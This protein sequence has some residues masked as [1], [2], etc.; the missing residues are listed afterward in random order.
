[1]AIFII[2]L[3][4][5][6][7]EA[8]ID[9]LLGRHVAWLKTCRDSG[10]FLAWGR[11]VPREGGVILAKAADRAEIES[12]AAGDPFV[13]E[14]AAEVSIVEWAPSFYGEGMEALGS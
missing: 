5:L 12:I 4:Y 3:E 11:K 2:S 10:H 7:P 9:A 13:T 8:E 6:V 1:M 14:G